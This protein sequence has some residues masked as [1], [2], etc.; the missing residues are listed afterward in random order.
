[1]FRAPFNYVLSNSVTSS[2]FL[3]STMKMQQG[4][5]NNTITV[6]RYQG[7]DKGSTGYKLLTALGWKEGE[8]LGAN[9]QGMK[10]HLKIKQKLDN[11]GIGA[12]EAQSKNDWSL[13]FINYDH[14]L[15]SLSEITSK[16]QNNDDES[17]SDEDSD[18]DEKEKEDLQ[19]DASNGESELPKHMQIERKKN[20]RKNKKIKVEQST[21]QE[22]SG[23]ENNSV[24]KDRRRKK[25][26]KK[27]L[28]KDHEISVKE[29]DNLSNITY[30][31]STENTNT[32]KRKRKS[33][34][35]KIQRKDDNE[36][37]NKNTQHQN[38]S[39]D[40]DSV[41][42][43]RQKSQISRHASM[44]RKRGQGKLVGNY[45]S[46]DLAAILGQ[47]N[48]QQQISQ[49]PASKQVTFQKQSN[50]IELGDE[51]LMPLIDNGNLRNQES[52]QNATDVN[53]NKWWLN[54][55]VRSS[56]VLGD[57]KPRQ[58]Q[59]QPTKQIQINGF[60]E[61]D[62]EAL[63]NRSKELQVQGRIGLGKKSQLDFGKSSWQGQKKLISD[64]EDEDDERNDINNDANIHKCQLNLQ[65]NRQKEIE[66]LQELIIQQPK[67]QDKKIKWRKVIKKALKKCK[68]SSNRKMGGRKEVQID[69]LIKYASDLVK[70][71]LDCE[72]TFKNKLLKQVGKMENLVIQ[73]EVLVVTQAA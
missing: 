51:N 34:K 67:K 47:T 41:D 42:E 31:Q 52:Q 70:K 38:P 73:D 11:E 54:F 25:E 4:S 26:S 59:Q 21:T 63:Y 53:I 72:Q 14:V 68:Q 43:A 58:L 13:S 9:K 35:T 39:S 65:Y 12:K 62:Q 10:T 15:K 24:D 17:S 44:Y 32:K 48:Q 29:I 7:V 57:F 5:T 2:F 49:K 61:E 20:K 27:G 3:P 64:S 16:H 28:A 18:R 1:M 50:T 46:T 8:G 69:E 6:S 19:S 23:I 33:Q 55:F 60:R 45:S 71:G 66:Q 56:D 37:E 22:T 40:S 36:E 30:S